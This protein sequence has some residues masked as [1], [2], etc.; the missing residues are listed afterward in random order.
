M[1]E[2]MHVNMRINEF[3]IFHFGWSWR[4]LKLCD[5]W[6][7]CLLPTSSTLGLAKYTFTVSTLSW[8]L[9][10]LMLMLMSLLLSPSYAG[11]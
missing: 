4:K 7:R 6:G 11:L 1:F 8:T 2:V 3:E 5:S 9:L 10:M